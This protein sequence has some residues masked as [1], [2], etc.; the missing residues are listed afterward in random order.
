MTR[1]DRDIDGKLN[2]KFG[3]IEPQVDN[4]KPE[5]TRLAIGCLIPS[6]VLISIVLVSVLIW[7]L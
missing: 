1:Y 3:N 6:S 5:K 7:G 4:W 2:Q